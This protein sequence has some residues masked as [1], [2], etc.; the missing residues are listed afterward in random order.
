VANLLISDGSV[1]VQLSGWE[2]AE[3]LHGDMTFPRSAITGVRVVSGCLD[4]VDGFKL[5][6]SGIP[7]AVK[8]GTWRGGQ[9]GSTFAACHGNGPGIIIELTG[10]HYSRIVL[11]HD[12]PEVLAAQLA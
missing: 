6:G 10:E 5:V 2:K 9:G 3:A 8:V 4:E 11:T 12:N 1:T 7:G